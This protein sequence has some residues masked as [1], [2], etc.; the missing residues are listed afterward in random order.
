MTPSESIQEAAPHSSAAFWRYWTASATSR[1]GA[2]VS[3]V[4]LPLVAL[5][6]LDASNF[7][8]GLLTAASYAAIVLVGLPAGVIVQRYPLRGLQVS[9]DGFR[10]V[11][12]LTIPVA[13]W[14]DLLTLPH[15]LLV[16]FLVGLASNLFDVANATFLPAIVPKDQLIARNGLLSGTFATTQLAGPALGG[17][18]VQAV[19]AALSLVVD[20]V[21]YLISAV[22]LAQIPTTARREPQA[23]RPGLLP[24]IAV[25]LGYVARHPV[26]RPC[27]IAATAVNFANGAILAVTAPFLVRSLDLAP[28]LVGVIFALDGLGSVVGAALAARLVRGIGDARAALLAISIGPLLGIAMPLT[29]GSWAPAVFGLGMTGL[30]AG[31]TIFSVIART[32]R[33]TVSPPDLLSRVMASVR[34]I[35]WSVIPLGALVAGMAAEVWA[36]RAGLVVACAA[37]FIA[38]AA[39]WL[40]R[41]PGLHQLEDGEQLLASGSATS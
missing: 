26:M 27:V 14:W 18:L 6:L 25:G 33:Q 40:S 34:F 9:M 38:P 36:P 11:A 15:L 22:L 39:V 29:A 21:S 13:A 23:T 12:I 19:G 30:A 2:G 35:S 31:V 28:A 24:Q 7:E 41:I 37:T 32:H 16:A 20:A 8:V 3:V 10:A 5:I 4:A 1:L 17:L